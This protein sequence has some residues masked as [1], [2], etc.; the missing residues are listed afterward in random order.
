MFGYWRSLDQNVTNLLIKSKINPDSIDASLLRRG[1]ISGTKEDEN[2]ISKMSQ[3]HWTNSGRQHAICSNYETRFE[4]G[5][6][7]PIRDQYSVSIS[8]YSPDRLQ[9]LV[10]LVKHFR[11]SK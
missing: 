5:G 10:R 6:K 3:Y 7:F 2:V 11:L 8:F 4:D 9:Y 1:E